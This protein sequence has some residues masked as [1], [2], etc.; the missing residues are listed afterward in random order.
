MESDKEYI[1]HSLLFCFY[2]KKNDAD[3]HRIICETYDE[4]VIAIRSMRIRLNNSK[5]VIWYQW[6]LTFQT[7]CSCKKERI[8]EKWEKVVENTLINLYCI[9]FSFWNKK[10]QK[11]G[12][13]FCTDLVY[14]N[15]HFMHISDEYA[16]IYVMIKFQNRDIYIRNE[17]SRI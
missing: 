15:M 3:A 13:K 14:Q 4:N 5:T 16:I 12:K 17:I 11:I 2:R 8:A 7:T 9:N 1:C 6:Q 10:L